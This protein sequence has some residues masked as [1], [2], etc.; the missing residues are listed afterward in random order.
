MFLCRVCAKCGISFEG[1]WYD[2]QRKRPCC[3]TCWG[4]SVYECA[5]VIILR[6]LDK[7][8]NHWNNWC[9]VKVLTFSEF[10]SSYDVHVFVIPAASKTKE[11]PMIRFRKVS[12][13]WA[14]INKTVFEQYVN[15]FVWRS[16]VVETGWIFNH[17]WQCD[18]I[19]IFIFF[20]SAMKKR[21]IFC[22]FSG[23][24]ILM[25]VLKCVL[26]IQTCTLMNKQSSS[27]SCH[28]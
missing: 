8:D 22:T 12:I 16:R 7:G 6:V 27:C 21:Q 9:R 3:P 19:F 2:K 28:P 10:D 13:V 5:N 23:I 15:V 11:H 24:M 20:S 14:L 26:K 18:F 17:C 1:T 4:M 25:K